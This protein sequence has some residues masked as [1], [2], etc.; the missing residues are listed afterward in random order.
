MAIEDQYWQALQARVCAKCVDG[1]GEGGCRLSRDMEC[2]MKKYFP[3]ILS[4][5][6]TTYSS[7]I[8]PYQEQLRNKVCGACIHQSPSGTCSLREGVDCALDRYFPLIVQVIEETQLKERLYK[9][10]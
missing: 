9:G 7:S 8:M 4:I 1:D 5:I 10:R 2:A 6:N 3:E